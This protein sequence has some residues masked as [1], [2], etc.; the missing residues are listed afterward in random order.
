M[1]LEFLLINLIASKVENVGSALVASSTS[2]F[3]YK[4]GDSIVTYVR[5][6]L[7]NICDSILQEFVCTDR[8]GSIEIYILQCVLINCSFRRHDEK[9]ESSAGRR[10]W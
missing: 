6:I 5:A 1:Y 2:S 4:I 7:A 3:T 9:V 8:F 10:Y